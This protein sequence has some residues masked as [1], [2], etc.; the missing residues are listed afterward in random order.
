MAISQT[1]VEYSSKDQRTST[2]EWECS[3]HGQQNDLGQ[4]QD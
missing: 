4:M 1:K 3:V 2:T